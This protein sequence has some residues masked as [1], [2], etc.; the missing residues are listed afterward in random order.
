[1]N[2]PA[3]IAVFENYAQT[4]PSRFACFLFLKVAKLNKYTYKDP[5]DKSMFYHEGF[6]KICTPSTPAISSVKCHRKISV[7]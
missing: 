6:C 4:S 3:I 7:Q 5:S 2:T 1:M